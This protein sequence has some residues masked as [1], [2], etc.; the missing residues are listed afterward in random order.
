MKTRL[1]NTLAG[2]T[3][4][5][6]LFGALPEYSQGQSIVF[7]TSTSSNG[8]LG[9]LAGA[10]ATCNSL[11]QT[12]GLS[13]TYVAW[14]STSTTDARDRIDDASYIRVDGTPIANNLADLI[15]GSLQ[16]AVLLDETGTTMAVR[17]WTGTLALGGVKN[18]NPAGN[19]C[20]D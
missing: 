17:V 20:S 15:D 9:G 2:L 10:D 4:A 5:L 6:L 18:P 8:D 11:A 13:G 1:L 16:N 12:A 7:V 14:L 19:L 3:M